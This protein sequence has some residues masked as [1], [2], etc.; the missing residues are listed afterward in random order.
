MTRCAG[1]FRG[2]TGDKS[3]RLGF[4]LWSSWRKRVKV[5]SRLGKGILSKLVRSCSLRS[6]KC[7]QR[8]LSGFFLNL[9]STS[10]LAPMKFE[11]AQCGKV[12]RSIF[13]A[14]DPYST[15]VAA[16]WG[17]DREGLDHF[18]LACLECGTLHDCSGS[19]AAII[20]MIG[21]SWRILGTF[22][23]ASIVEAY[24]KSGATKIFSR[25][26]KE[27][28]GLPELIVDQLTY[29]GLFPDP[30]EQAKGYLSV[31]ELEIWKKLQPD[32]RGRS[33]KEN[34][35]PISRQPRSP[36]Q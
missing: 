3:E 11:C 31:E 5:C 10:K 29:A 17:R 35:P 16:R 30:M 2:Q 33:L 23:A 6:F 22:K 27:D 20:P 24:R 26:A 8:G 14:R 25:F 21:N 13:G 7:C 36:K 32:S 1:A 15:L 28:A 12:H 34:P 9:G 19:V 18:L 4:V